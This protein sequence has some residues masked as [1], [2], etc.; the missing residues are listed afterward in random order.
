[1]GLKTI[2][3]NFIIWELISQLHRTSV[4]RLS[5]R[6]FFCVSRAP[7]QG[8]LCECYTL[9]LS[10]NYL[11]NCTRVRYTQGLFQAKIDLLGEGILGH[12]GPTRWDISLDREW[13][14]WPSYGWECPGIRKTSCKKTLGTDFLFPNQ[15]S[16]GK[17]GTA[18]EE[19]T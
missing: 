18:G 17:N 3:H 4:T 14:G 9:E 15:L 19:C 6:I 16:Q 8:T 11:S 2:T 7:P 13:P 12:Q 5:G 1:M 10:D